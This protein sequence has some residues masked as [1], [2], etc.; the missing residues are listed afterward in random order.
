MIEFPPTLDFCLRVMVLNWKDIIWGVERG[1]FSWKDV[2]NFALA[3][4]D[5]NSSTFDIENEISMLDKNNAS[6]IMS[7]ARDAASIDCEFGNIA[8]RWRFLLLKWIYENRNTFT[9]PL[10]VVEEL[11]AEFDYPQDMESFVPFLPPSDGWDPTKHSSSENEMR[12]F[13]NW[14]TYLEAPKPDS[15]A[16]TQA[17]GGL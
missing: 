8:D 11:Y 10:G 13:G 4:L 1:I 9:H 2:R 5:R 15:F 17:P 3:K 7:L 16:L 12:L 14:R 6:E